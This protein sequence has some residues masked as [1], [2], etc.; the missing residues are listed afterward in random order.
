MEKDWVVLKIDEQHM[1]VTLAIKKP[2]GEEHPVFSAEFIE[3]YLKENGISYG[4]DHSAI[5]ALSSYVA[6]EREVIVARGREAVDG[7]DG[8]FQYVISL[9][10]VRDKPVINKDGSV[11]YY[12]S[13]KLAMLEAD[14]LFAVYM[15]PTEGEMGYTVFSEELPPIRGREQRPLQGR[16][17]YISEDNREYRAKEA[18]RIF[19]KENKIIIE[20]IYIVQGDLDIEKGNIKF[21]GDVE[22]KGDVRSGLKI[23]AGGDVFI[24]GHVGS[25]NIIAGGNITIKNGVQGRDKCIIMAKGDIACSFVE[26]ATVSAEGNVY[27]DSLLDCHVA[28]K[29]TVSVCSK[30]GVII[31]GDVYGMQGITAKEC[32]NNKDVYTRLQI[33]VIPEYIRQLNEVNAKLKK[34]YEDIELLDRN[35]KICDSIEGCKRTKETE[36]IRMKIMRAKVILSAEKKVLEDEKELRQLDIER[37][38]TEAV[39]HIKGTV[40]TN[41]LVHIGM[42]K[43]RVKDACKNVIFR[44]KNEDVIMESAKE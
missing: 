16:G 22:V 12:N 42:G 33:G 38:K 34:L 2:E 20:S 8:Y 1:W 40:Y 19:R 36:A 23:E 26:R 10:D 14:E 4:I 3:N 13:L 7:K 39:V 43:Y 30:R 18:G 21:N 28:A 11:D 41:T 31:G 17:F 44:H 15:P 24:H 32:G 6:Y 9:E 27:A 29:Q 35:M 5:Q 25:C 37:S